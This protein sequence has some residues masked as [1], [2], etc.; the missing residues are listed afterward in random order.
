VYSLSRAA[1]ASSDWQAILAEVV[2]AL[3]LPDFYPRFSRACE[4][5]SGY[6]STLVVWLSAEHR[7]IH[8]YDDLPEEFAGETKTAWFEGAYLLDPFYG[9]FTNSAP[10]GIYRLHDLAPD[11]FFDS[12]Y[13]R[14]Y[15]LQTGLTDEIGLLINLDGEHAILIS[16]GNRH[17]APVDPAQLSDLQTAMPVLAQLCRRQQ[18]A[19]AGQINFS[20]PL[21]RAFRN[22]GRDHLSNRE[23]EVVQLI[24]KGHSNKSIAQLLEISV[25]TVKVYNKRFH[26]KL[27]VTSQAELFS[28][29]LEAIS[30]VPFDADVDPL[31]HYREITRR[32]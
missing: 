11:S 10:D 28:L 12:E 1:L 31:T 4:F 18:S 26:A 5:L 29:F 24:L 14:S 30:L 19:G 8:L 7:P 32:P 3:A 15:Y 25:D 20:A 16:L 22:F 9:L 2:G 17:S 21:D 23:C 27:E 13:Y 6:Q